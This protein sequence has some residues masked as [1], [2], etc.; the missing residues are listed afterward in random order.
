M[1]RIYRNL[2]FASVFMILAGV[3][4]S[5]CERGVSEGV[6]GNPQEGEFP[7]FDTFNIPT[8][9]Y[10]FY[11]KFDGHFKKWQ[12]GK[13]SKWDTITRKDPKDPDFPDWGSWPVYTENIY[14][15][16][17]EQ[18]NDEPCIS[19]SG[20]I[21]FEHITRFIRPEIPNERIE[22]FFYDCVNEADQDTIDAQNGF[23][24]E[25]VTFLDM[26]RSETGTGIAQPFAT[27]EFGRR[28]AKLVYTDANRDRWVSK[29]G[30]GQLLDSYIRI[31]DLIKRNITTD[32]LDTLGM[33][34]VEGEFAGRLFNGSQN[35]PITEAKF[36]ARLVP[37]EP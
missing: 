32:T 36:R 3:I 15:N 34:I 6:F 17:P 16:I 26:F 14:R 29:P 5:S 37:R 1:S 18:Y 27:T 11:G 4:V 33:Y 28:G 20:N 21:W 2:A 7:V 30:S 10:F 25:I 19:D 23:H 35:I 13:R 12:D 24:P 9:N 8:A 31:T 22:I